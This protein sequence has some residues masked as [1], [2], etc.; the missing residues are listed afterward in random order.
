MLDGYAEASTLIA[1]EAP[2]RLDRSSFAAAI[3]AAVN[4]P[5]FDFLFPR[6]L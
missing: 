2:L 4:G 3:A 1:L 5:R 6:I